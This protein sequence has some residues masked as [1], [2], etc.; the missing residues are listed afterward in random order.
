MSLSAICGLFKDAVSSSDY[1]ASD[2]R[3]INELDMKG[4]DRGRTKDTIPL[5]SWRTEENH[6]KLE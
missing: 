4:S 5:F 3:M 1:I 2:D 6:E